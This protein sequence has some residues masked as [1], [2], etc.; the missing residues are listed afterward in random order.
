MSSPCAPTAETIR[1]GQILRDARE[2]AGLTQRALAERLGC[3]QPAVSQAE[4]GG[5][6]LSIATLQR[7]ADALGCD[8][9]VSIVTRET[10]LS[11]GAPASLT[12]GR[13]DEATAHGSG[14]SGWD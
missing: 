6:S 11:T 5:A 13:P 1:A 3:T 14:R 8:L 7:F 12:A 9:Q 10:A 2:C 4:A